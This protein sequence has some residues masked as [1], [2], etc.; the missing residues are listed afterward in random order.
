MRSL[1]LTCITSLLNLA[2]GF[3]QDSDTTA[4][5]P[6]LQNGSIKATVQ[7]ETKEIPLN[8]T[9][10]FLLQIIWQGDLDRYEIENLENPVLTNFEIL[11]NSSSNSVG[12]EAGLKKA[13]K[14]HE[15]VLQPTE[16]G[17][18]YVD[19]LIVEY[20]DMESGK[21]G[22]LLTNRLEA[23]VIDPIRERSL[24]PW[25]IGGGVILLLALI[26]SG[27]MAYSKRKKAKAAEEQA[28]ALEMI[29]IEEK[30]LVELREKVDLQ[31]SEVVASFSSL[32]SIFRSYLS[33]RYHFAAKGMTTAEIGSDLTK[34][35]VPNKIIEQAREALEACDKAKFS[36]GQVERSVVE[37]SYT[38]VED[39]LHQGMAVASVKSDAE[40]SK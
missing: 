24:T 10:T 5:R 37:R 13:V 16:L 36:G 8:R 32:S 7:L 15:F 18:A 31:N 14:A 2:V 6:S 23:K 11:S 21:R 1:T 4:A 12:F 27:G 28:K 35:A 19:G 25:L 26:S 34:L 38:L 17:M 20:I 29:P 22:H 33:E 3:S 9:T 30:Y 39:I 40:Q